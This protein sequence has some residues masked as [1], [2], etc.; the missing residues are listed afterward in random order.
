M[1]FHIILHLFYSFNNYLDKISCL[2]YYHTRGLFASHLYDNSFSLFSRIQVSQYNLYLGCLFSV[3][4][5]CLGDSTDRL[6]HFIKLFLF[7]HFLPLI[8]LS[9]VECWTYF[10]VTNFQYGH[11][12][13]IGSSNVWSYFQQVQF[14]QFIYLIPCLRMFKYEC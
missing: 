4:I 9:S 5:T 3:E 1:C 2:V 12:S 8:S 11:Y 7:F 6:S 13:C 14:V 10:P